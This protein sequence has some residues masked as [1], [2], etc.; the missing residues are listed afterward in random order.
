[1][2]GIDDLLTCARSIE[3]TIS[4]GPIAHSVTPA[5]IRGHLS[6]HYDFSQSLPLEDVVSDVQRMLENWQTQVTHPRYL[7]LFNPSVTDASIIAD[8]LVAAYNPQLAAWRTSPAANEIERHTLAWVARRFGLPD[9]TFANF[10]SG[11][12]ESNLT[13]VIVALTGAFPNY[14]DD[15]IRGLPALPLIYLTAEAHHSFNKIA[16]AT[17]LGRRALRLVETDRDLKMDMEDLARKVAAE[18]KNG[19][20]PFMVV[21]TAGTYAA[22]FIDPLPDL[23]AFCGSEKL[24]FHV[25]GAWGAAAAISPRLRTHLSGI[26]AADSVICDAHKWFSV[27]MSAGM[28]FCRHDEAVRRAFRAQ[29]FYMPGKTAAVDDPYNT[30]TQWSRRFIGLKLFMSLANLGEAGYIR[31]VEEQTRLGNVLRDLLTRMGWTIAN[32]TPLP[33]V[34]FTRHGLNPSKF[35]Q[36]LYQKEIAWMSEVQIA[37]RP[38]IRACVTSFKT[39]EADIEWIVRRIDR[40]IPL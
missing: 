3:S 19:M 14:G 6:E 13:A 38:A 31:M 20:I 26:E 28:F 40:E 34:C 24:W 4:G 30:S 10:T 1:M 8:T 17:G 15:G 23:A 12:A 22:G 39:T 9:G 21:G 27:P 2:K 35:L 32:S 16:H 33:V 11:G 5:E 29:A 7:G 37:G 25:D 36:L 18:R